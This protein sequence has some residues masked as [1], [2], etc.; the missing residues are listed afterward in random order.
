MTDSV[1]RPVVT[2]EETCA[3][4]GITRQTLWRWRR[5]GGFPEPLDT[6]G[7]LRWSLADLERFDRSGQREAL[8]A[9]SHPHGPSGTIPLSDGESTAYTEIRRIGRDLGFPED[10]SPAIIGR[11]ARGVIRQAKNLAD[12]IKGS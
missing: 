8:Q 7:G 4:Y 6:G 11:Q 12:R 10:T 2:Q 5:A 1:E 9:Q 3:R